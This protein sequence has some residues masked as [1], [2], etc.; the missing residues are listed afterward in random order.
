MIRMIKDIFY[1]RSAAKN[2]KK[3]GVTHEYDWYVYLYYY[4]LDSLKRYIL[5]KLT[6]KFLRKKD[7]GELPF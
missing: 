2:A 4:E 7:N 5:Y 1:Y 6:P 3:Y